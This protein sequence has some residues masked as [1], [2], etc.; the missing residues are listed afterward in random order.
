[1]ASTRPRFL[2]PNPAGFRRCRLLHDDCPELSAVAPVLTTTAPNFGGA[3]V[4][5]SRVAPNQKPSAP[6]LGTIAPALSVV[7]PTVKALAPEA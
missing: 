4:L 3:S 6:F 2:Y 5:A 1:M 7:A